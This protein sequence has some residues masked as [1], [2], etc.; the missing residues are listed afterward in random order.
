MSR[1]SPGPE[2]HQASPGV[3]F[4]G[5]CVTCHVSPGRKRATRL[6][7]VVCGPCWAAHGGK[8]SAEEMG[9]VPRETAPL[10][11]PAGQRHW[12]QSLKRAEWVQ[13][14]RVDGRDNLLDIAR[15]LAL[16]ADWHTLE[17]WPGW[18][19]LMART[20]LSETTIQRWLQELR[21]RG[22]LEVIE[23][24]STPMTRPM[25][26]TLPNGRVLSRDEGNRRAVYALRI[27]LSPDEALRWAAESITAQAAQE[28][29][30]KAEK[31]AEKNAAELRARLVDKVRALFTKAASTEYDCER[32]A[33]T[34]KAKQLI[35]QHALT[36]IELTE[37][38]VA[39]HERWEQAWRAR[40]ARAAEILYD[41]IMNAPGFKEVYERRLRLQEQW[42]ADQAKR[43]P[44]A[45]EKGWPTGLFSVG[46]KTWVGGYAREARVVD[47]CGHPVTDQW[48][49]NDQT[50]ALRAPSIDEEAARVWATKVPT[51]G[52]EML[53]AAAW[54]RRRLP[55]FGRMTRKA[56]RAAIRPFWA[57]GWSNLDVVHALDHRPAAFGLTGGTPI[58][59]GDDDATD[60]QTAWWF[61]KA[62]LNVWRDTDGRPRRGFYQGRQRNRAVRQAVAEHHGRAA[63]KLLSDHDAELTVAHIVAHGRRAARELGSSAVPQPRRPRPTTA[64]QAA[65]APDAVIRAAAA[66]QLEQALA[67]KRAR[68]A[69]RARA[70]LQAKFG[71]Q[72]DAARAELAA[73]TA[74]AVPLAPVGD[75]DQLTPYER[76]LAVARGHRRNAARQNP[77]AGKPR[78]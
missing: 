37:V 16:Q 66:E 58:R 65:T 3:S 45:D 6:F 22:W 63:A 28:A 64:D 20:G 53:I 36:P 10:R 49:A 38:D 57:A 15:V 78:R 31:N 69:E 9:P 56:V 8:P 30:E 27:P 76:A 17:T 29:A 35:A 7:A 4:D 18:D 32:D 11:Y 25:A 41:R 55:V 59:R 1:I 75:D 40:Q 70:E 71:A 2:P 60:A 13:D 42:L 72:L 5:P 26:L 23:T 52:F 74:P 34:T 77:R 62:R 43:G 14:I 24:G 68:D 47:D 67:A 44:S 19:T 46:K 51:S 73:R 48:G 21:L 12:R 39:K 50:S 61:I 54:L 33:L